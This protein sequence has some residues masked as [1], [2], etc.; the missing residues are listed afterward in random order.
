M[1][2]LPANTQLVVWINNMTNRINSASDCRSLAVLEQEIA[3]KINALIAQ[4]EKQIE[5]LLIQMTAPTNLVSTILWIENWIQVNI[6]QP[7]ETLVAENIQLVQALVQLTAAIN[8]K[9]ENLS[10]L[11]HPQQ[12]LQTM[13]AQVAGSIVIGG[14]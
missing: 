14:G 5:Q 2:L 11:A 3:S 1:S 6:V 13:G 10:C 7:Y 4:K 8:S 12:T 9:L